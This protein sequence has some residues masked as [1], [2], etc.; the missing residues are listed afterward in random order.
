MTLAFLK[1]AGSQS[2]HTHTYIIL[3]SRYRLSIGDL[4]PIPEP[5]LMKNPPSQA[6]QV[7]LIDVTMTTLVIK[8]VG[9]PDKVEFPRRESLCTGHIEVATAQ[10]RFSSF[11]SIALRQKSQFCLR[12]NTGPIL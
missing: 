2:T 7:I 12:G 8:K 4:P 1:N 6:L 11:I 9:D 5:N 3:V 10:P